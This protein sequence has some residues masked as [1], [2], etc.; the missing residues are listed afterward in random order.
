MEI[1]TFK[2]QNLTTWFRKRCILREQKENR[3][4]SFMKDEKVEVYALKDSFQLCMSSLPHFYD[5]KTVKD[6][7]KFATAC[8][9]DYLGS[10]ICYF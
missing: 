6:Q 9:E 10:R 7:R 8:F 2:V 3:T 4:H 1:I 5:V